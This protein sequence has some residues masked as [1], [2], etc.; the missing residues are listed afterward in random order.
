MALSPKY[1]TESKQSESLSPYIA[2]VVQLKGL[3]NYCV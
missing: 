2:L 1:Y 3:T